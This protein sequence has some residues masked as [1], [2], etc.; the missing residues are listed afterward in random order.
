MSDEELAAIDYL[1]TLADAKGV[2]CSTMSNGH[3][4][5]FKTDYLRALLEQ[6]GDKPKIAFFV[7]RPEL[8][9]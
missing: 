3:M 6:H 8:Q 7:H 5:V 2:A 9:G 4:L 1:N